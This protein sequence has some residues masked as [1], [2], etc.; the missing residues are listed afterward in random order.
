MLLSPIGVGAARSQPRCAARGACVDGH[1]QPPSAVPACRPRRRCASLARCS[2][3]S[4]AA[5]KDKPDWAGGDLLSGIVN[6]AISTPGVYD[7]MKLAARQTLISTAEKNGIPWRGEVERWSGRAEELERLAA[8]LTDASL[9]MPDYYLRPFHAYADGNLCWLAAQEAESATYSMALRVWP[10]EAAEGTLSWR[11]AAA[12]LRGSYTGAV[13]SYMA[14]RGVAP[15]S[16]VLDVGCSV[17][18]STRALADAF[19][20][21]T[22]VLGLDLSP[23]MLT[24]A[25]ARSEEESAHV[26]G[27]AAE[28]RQRVSYRHAA[29]EATGLP[30]SSID[31][32]SA[33]FL[34]HELPQS[35]SRALLA[36]A[37]LVLAPSTGVFAMTDNDPRSPIIQAL[38]PVLFTL[39][40]S[41]EPHSDE[42]YTFDV[43]GAMRDAGFVDV[44]SVR[45]DPRHRTV[46]GRKP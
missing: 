38:P 33:A 8:Q 24:V 37:F 25:V 16:R 45:T 4:P 28:Q 34:M 1:A 30:Q 26:G 3:S 5:V 23:Y 42:Y 19:P 6:A 36:E 40:K 44:T 18:L 17:G 21:A 20:S 12:R 39:M 14:A 22:S 10:Q 35:A 2:A 41:T 11:A 46:M 43:E 7:L 31:L 32:F 27:T 9:P 29:G 15:P 13:A